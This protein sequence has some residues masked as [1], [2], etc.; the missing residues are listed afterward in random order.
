MSSNWTSVASRILSQLIIH[1]DGKKW[2][3]KY[4]IKTFKFT[5]IKADFINLLTCEEHINHQIDMF[6]FAKMWKNKE[7]A[8]QIVC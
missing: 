6:T 7:I 2:L 8:L 3:R 4:A 1:G 5:N